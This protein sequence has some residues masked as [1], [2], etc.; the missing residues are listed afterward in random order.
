MKKLYFIF[1]FLSLYTNIN[2]QHFIKGVI[3]DVKGKPV[4]DSHIMLYSSKDSLL[5]IRESISD[6]KGCFE[7]DE[8]STGDYKIVVTNV[9]YETETVTVNNLYQNIKMLQVVLFEKNM[10]LKEVT[11][12]AS[13]IVRKFDR[14]IIFPSEQEKRKSMNGVELV[15][16]MQLSR[17]Y[18]DKSNN[19]I[20]A[21][22]DGKVLLRINGSPADLSD[23]QT[24]NPN[25]VTRVEYHDM[26]SMR[27]GDSE[28][29]IDFYVRHRDTGGNG[30]ATTNVGLT[31]EVGDM[32]ASIKVNHQESEFSVYGKY[33]YAHFDDRYTNAN[34]TYLFEDNTSLHRYS[35]GISGFY[36]ERV[37][38][39][40]LGYAYFSQNSF[41]TAKASYN[42][43][44][45]PISLNKSLIYMP[46][47]YI[48]RND[49]TYHE[50]RKPSFN[51]YYQKDID[52]KQFLALDVVGT[53]IYTDSYEKYRELDNEYS[54]VDIYSDILGQKYSIIAEGIYEFKAKK[55][56]LS[57]GLKQNMNFSDNEYKT[58]TLSVNEMN[59]YITNVYS[60]WT[61][62]WK[63]YS[64]GIGVGG[65]YTKNTYKFRKNDT[66]LNFKPMIKL[67]LT[68]FR[69]L[70][71]RYQGN[72]SVQSPSIG[73]MNDAEIEK[74]GY[75]I[76]KGNP[77]L[78]NVIEYRNLLMLTFF[79]RTFNGS[80][81]INYT[82]IN[83][84]ILGHTYREENKFIF[85]MMNGDNKQSLSV[86]GSSRLFLFGRK[87]SVTA[88]IGYIYNKVVGQTYT[89]SLNTWYLRT[90]VDYTYKSL[91]C[92]VDYAKESDLLV[93]GE[94]LI[95]RG[96][97]IS[98][99]L[100]Y[101]KKNFRIGLK[102][103][104]QI[105]PCLSRTVS[106]NQYVQTD[107]ELF[108]PGTRSIFRLNL[109]WNFKW[110]N[111]KNRSEQRIN[112]T[113]EDNGV[114]K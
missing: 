104:W 68:P 74:D 28:V 15:D 44:S 19:S 75:N 14:Q 52:K 108:S 46:N 102:Y 22:T 49:S 53:H 35:E 39:L 66:Y 83:H 56:K 90:G 41:F 32:Q 37:Y 8:I 25:E 88:R 99:G 48:Y 106:L 11:V 63:K 92:W 73:Y 98:C 3:V 30:M 112:N 100:N 55:G 71:F 97:N 26:P 95:E 103:N 65:T 58:E 113:D 109:T 20:N 36:K 81:D 24:I 57:V 6:R 17:V 77:N 2:A 51:L 86:N 27:Y 54:T 60:E 43:F 85:Q 76:R 1:F 33:D 89:H 50:E 94:T 4:A 96:E 79:Q 59:Q 21:I 38:Q 29:V 23:V 34:E 82:Y 13:N 42:H 62:N 7:F 84:P 9:Q 5:T 72:V 111:Q 70:I 64:Y 12:E 18:V 47:K 45:I 16:N 101:R 105:N 67:G 10:L 80:I 107:H 110:G 69:E 40:R 87:L 91:T 78:K 31:S 61:G 93:N 114:L